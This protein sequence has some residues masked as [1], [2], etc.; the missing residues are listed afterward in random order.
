MR[1]PLAPG[2]GVP[3]AARLPSGAPLTVARPASREKGEQRGPSGIRSRREHAPATPSRVQH[4]PAVA[5]PTVAEG[6]RRRPPGRSPPPPLLSVVRH[7]DRLAAA[8]LVAARCRAA[9]S[10]CRNPCLGG[11]GKHAESSQSDDG[12]NNSPTRTPSLGGRLAFA[13][14]WRTNAIGP[15]LARCRASAAWD[16]GS[17]IHSAS[18]I[19]IPRRRWPHAPDPRVV[20]QHDGQVHPE[21]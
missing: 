15:T 12:V 2:G 5:S 17:T 3:G 13:V 6:R 4:R 8:D 9:P 19:G 18:H 16:A 1:R 11:R 10:E 20:R 14:S 21:Q 7:S